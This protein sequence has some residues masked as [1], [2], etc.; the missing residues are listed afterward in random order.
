MMASGLLGARAR[1]GWL[2]WGDKHCFMT[3]CW[4]AN[5]NPGS[6]SLFEGQKD[7]TDS[8]EHDF[9]ISTTKESRKLIVIA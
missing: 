7:P 3:R 9:A 2:E 8:K 4:R 1:C 6:G 5:D